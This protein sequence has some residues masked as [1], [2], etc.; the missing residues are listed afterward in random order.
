MEIVSDFET[1]NYNKT[2]LFAGFLG[3]FGIHRIANGRYVTGYL[4]FV[5]A[6][7]SFIALGLISLIVYSGIKIAVLLAP[8]FIFVIILLSLFAT[9][10][11]VEIIA[12]NFK[13]K[14]TNK[15]VVSKNKIYKT[16]SNYLALVIPVTIIGSL[17]FVLWFIILISL[18]IM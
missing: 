11:L 7:I 15:R 18:Y 16:W 10:D 13:N 8:F 14:F 9:A 17:M 5:A 6:C 2:V 12:G 4:M 3:V 1:S